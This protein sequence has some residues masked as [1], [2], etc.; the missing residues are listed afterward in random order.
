MTGFE[1]FI[2]HLGAWTFAGSIAVGSLAL[3]GW[4]ER[5]ADRADRRKHR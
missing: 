1:N 3:V 4:V 2:Y 5:M